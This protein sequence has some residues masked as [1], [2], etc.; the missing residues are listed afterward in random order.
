MAKLGEPLRCRCLLD[1]WTYAAALPAVSTLCVIA[2]GCLASATNDARQ[3]TSVAPSPVKETGASAVAAAAA[4]PPAIHSHEFKPLASDSATVGSSSLPAEKLRSFSPPASPMP[5]T[6]TG[7]PA[8]EQTGPDENPTEPVFAEPRDVSLAEFAREGQRQLASLG[9]PWAPAASSG[10]VRTRMDLAGSNSEHRA[11]P[12]APFVGVWAPDIKAC[13]APQSAQEF[14]PTIVKT[15]RA[16][17]GDVSC[18]FR[19]I[20]EVAGGWDVRARCSSPHE[21]WAARIRL[22][23]VRNRLTWASER[24]S[25]EYVRCSPQVEVAVAR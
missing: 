3:V 23:V 17:A 12:V 10:D 1:P 5:P 19:S 13:A 6:D 24:G 16:R 25:Q 8:G 2:Y 18:V 11:H 21:H 22:S 20:R 7:G 4:L 14:L 9:Y 15:D